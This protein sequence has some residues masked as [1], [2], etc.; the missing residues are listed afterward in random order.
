MIA[1][2]T[3]ESEWRRNDVTSHV[4]ER[5]GAFVVLGDWNFALL[6]IAGRAQIVTSHLGPHGLRPLG[7]L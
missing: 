4:T 7:G 5:V 3:L 2:D 1:I 6:C